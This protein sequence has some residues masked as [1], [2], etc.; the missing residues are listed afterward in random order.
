MAET[1]R[2]K[3]A[4]VR[5]YRPEQFIVGCKDPSEDLPE[6][7]KR[8]LRAFECPVFK[9]TY[10]EAEF[11]KI[12]INMTLA[13]QV[14][15]ANRLSEVAKKLGCEWDNIKTVLEHDKRI[16][17]YSYLTPGDWRQSSHLLRDWVTLQTL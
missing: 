3:D 8:Y 7:F 5:A 14:E 9:M 11:S 1:L 17:K 13:S 10:E 12:A 6:S 16:G 4:E 15:N 2:V